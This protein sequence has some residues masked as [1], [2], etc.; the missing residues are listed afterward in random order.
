MHAAGRFK[1]I[2]FPGGASV[3]YELDL[4]DRITAI[5]NKASPGGQAYV[6][7][8]QRD[9]VGNI[10]NVTDPFNGET[11]FTFDLAGRQSTRTLP[12]GISTEWRYNWKD[13]VTNIA[14]KIGGTVLASVAYE[15]APGG[16]PTKVTREDGSYVELQ[17]DAAFRLIN[18]LYKAAGGAV[19][20]QIGYGYDKSGDRILL[21]R[22]GVILTNSVSQGYRI[23]AIKDA[24]NGATMES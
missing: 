3:R 9:S 4:L 16:E 17:Y 10:T 5:T 15:R 18:E 7:R 21:S 14:H 2:D 12:N 19:V 8:Y 6:T 20:D 22:K 23:T 1:G 13:Q 24:S 11:H